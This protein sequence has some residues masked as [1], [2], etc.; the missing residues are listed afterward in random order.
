MCSMKNVRCWVS[1]AKESGLG[2]WE[3]S[4]GRLSPVSHATLPSLVKTGHPLHLCCH[5]LGPWESVSSLLNSLQGLLQW[6]SLPSAFQAPQ[7]HP[8]PPPKQLSQPSLHSY[9]SA[10]ENIRDLPLAV[11]Q[12]QPPGLVLTLLSGLEATVRFPSSHRHS[13]L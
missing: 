13:G 7:I 8:L 6:V 11:E 9:F 5:R 4:R 1:G 12:I 3:S 2:H 10:G